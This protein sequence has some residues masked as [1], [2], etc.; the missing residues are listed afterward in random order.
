M[1]ILLVDA[2]HMA[3]ILNNPGP[4]TIVPFIGGDAM[5]GAIRLGQ[6]RVESFEFCKRLLEGAAKKLLREPVDP[7]IEL[8]LADIKKRHDPEGEILGWR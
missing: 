3:T 5:F 1:W 7:D 6:W 8:A 4:N 2:N